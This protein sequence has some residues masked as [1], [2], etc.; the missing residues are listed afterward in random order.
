MLF[1]SDALYA[2][3]YYQN[4]EVLPSGQP[5][6]TP[7]FGSEYV[8]LGF[9][10]DVSRAICSFEKNDP[11]FIKISIH[12]PE[13]GENPDG[14]DMEFQ[15]FDVNGYS[16]MMQYFEEEDKY[17]FTLDR[18]GKHCSFDGYPATDTYGWEYPDL[19]TVHAMLGDA[20]KSTGKE[21]YYKPQELFKRTVN[22]LFGMSVSELF[23]IG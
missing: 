23:E 1:R 16:L 18:N 14:W 22:E 7:S 20:F 4:D 11:H 10:T 21:M 15:D 5:S 17:H 12:K 13:W 8:Q 19:E 6:P 2:L 3:P 9:T